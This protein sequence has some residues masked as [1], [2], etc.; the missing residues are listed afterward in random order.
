MAPPKCLLFCYHTLPR[1][2]TISISKHKPKP[3]TQPLLSRTR[4]RHLTTPT[5]HRLTARK[6]PLAA[7]SEAP[8]APFQSPKSHS[9]AINSTAAP[10]QRKSTRSIA[11]DDQKSLFLPTSSPIRKPEIPNHRATFACDIRLS[12][13][14][15]DPAD[16]FFPAHSPNPLAAGPARNPAC[17]ATAKAFGDCSAGR[18]DSPLLPTVGGQKL[19]GYTHKKK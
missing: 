4:L 15:A 5:V 14:P 19:E 10:P 7:E 11:V 9:T 18:S 1:L 2:L 17:Q 3:K 6:A 13:D 12:A 8:A 16:L